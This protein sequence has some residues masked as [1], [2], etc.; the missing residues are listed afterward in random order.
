MP[1]FPGAGAMAASVEPGLTPKVEGGVAVHIQRV[2]P[3]YRPPVY[4]PYEFRPREEFRPA[5]P[6]GDIGEL[7][8]EYDAQPDVMEV[9][10]RS[11]LPDEGPGED[12]AEYD[13]ETQDAPPQCDPNDPDC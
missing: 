7:D 4:R 5:D 2:R 13:T 11:E 12:S 10:P 1:I 9:A 3:S 8:R 6:N